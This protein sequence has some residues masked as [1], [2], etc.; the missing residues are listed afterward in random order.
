MC[1]LAEAL[2]I[3]DHSVD[4]VSSVYL[5]HEVPADIRSRISTE[6]ARVLKRSGRLIVVDSLQFGDRPEYDGMLSGFPSSFHEPYY[7]E[8]ARSDL[9]GMFAAAG[10]TLIDERLAFLSKVMVF[11]KVS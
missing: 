7:C 3:A 6:A 8:Y 1:G 2:P 5:L 4:I 9:I 10:F 11:D